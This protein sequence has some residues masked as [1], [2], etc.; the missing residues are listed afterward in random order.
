MPNKHAELDL[1]DV[2]LAEQ[3]GAVVSI[4]GI[5]VAL[6]LDYCFGDFAFESNRIDRPSSLADNGNAIQIGDLNIAR[7][8]APNDRRIAVRGRKSHAHVIVL[9]LGQRTQIPAA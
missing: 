9:A 2:V 8:H 5:A 6:D 1:S 4:V 3:L 7:A